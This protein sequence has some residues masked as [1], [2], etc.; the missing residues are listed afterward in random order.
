MKL[1]ILGSGSAVPHPH[2]ASAAFWLET[3]S[4]SVL[5]DCS[6][7]AAH[8]MAAENLD[9]ANLDAIWISHLHLDHCAGLASLLFGLKHAPHT[10]GRNKPLRIIGC[11]GTRKLLKAVD[12]S[13]EYGLLNQP[14]PVKLQEVSTTYK[15]AFEVLPSL[16]AQV[17]ATGHTDESLALRITERDE[18]TF[19][20]TSD[21]GFS[22]EL[23]DFARNTDLLL[24][25]C[26]FWRHRKTDKHLEL[27]DAMRLAQLA[28]PGTVILTHFYDEWDG[29]DIESKASE[30]WPGKTIAAQDGLVVEFG[31]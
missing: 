1:V 12:D 13:N 2:R 16:R 4:G 25:E 21:T 17:F 24:I 29:V 8:R 28:E 3:A 10:Q 30:L 6:S 15:A 18:T 5:L 9:W 23:V 31:R 20:Y 27:A 19:V 26:S 7:D 22:A 11:K 14:F